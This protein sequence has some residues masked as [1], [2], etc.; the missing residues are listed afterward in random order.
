ME[1]LLIIGK[2]LGDTVDDEAPV[3]GTVHVT[4]TL[5]F[6]DPRCREDLGLETLLPNALV[7]ARPQLPLGEDRHL[8]HRHQL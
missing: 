1:P 2:Q 4:S 3:P 8:R 5:Q 6:V 7:G